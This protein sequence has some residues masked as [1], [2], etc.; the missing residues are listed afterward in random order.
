[1]RI[2]KDPDA[3]ERSGATLDYTGALEYLVDVVRR[4]SLARDLHAIT[5]IVRRAARR[6]TGAD[7]AALILREG[8][9]SYFAGEDAIAPLWQ[10]RRFPMRECVSG[11]AMIHR[12]P[13]AIENVT[14]DARVPREIYGDTFVQSMAMVPIRTENP[15][16]ALANYWARPHVATEEELRLLQ[17]L[18]DATAVV[19]ENVQLYAQL[20]ERVRE[21]TTQLEAANEEIRQLSLTDEL[22]GLYNRRGFLVLATQQLRSARRSNSSAWLMFADIDGLKPVN[23]QLGHRAGDRLLC[24]AARVLRESF[25]ELDVVA[26]IGGDEFAIFGVTEQVAEK[27]ESRLQTRIQRYNTQCEPG[28]E[29][30]LSTGLV[31]CD[32]HLHLSLDKLLDEADGAMY[33]MKRTR[34]AST[35]LA[36]AAS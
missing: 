34:K 24:A 15:V 2:A 14:S 11:W 26:R 18:A 29:L 12:Q 4:L 8:D 9:H 32:P 1:M 16:G 28:L 21:R 13:V 10:G 23:D 22:T 20:E 31:R 3:P 6:L 25:R 27:I 36:R 19:L 7:G 35:K 17:A 33:T 5:E 30:S